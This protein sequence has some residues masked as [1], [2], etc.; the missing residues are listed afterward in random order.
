MG[1]THSND[2][3][4]LVSRCQYVDFT[5]SVDYAILADATIAISVYATQDCWI[6]INPPGTYQAA[7]DPGGEKTP[8]NNQTFVPLGV[9]VDYPVHPTDGAGKIKI[10]VIRDSADG[11][12]HITER[13]V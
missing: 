6:T 8:V 11:R 3:L 4:L 10:S 2:N 9:I 7:A 12:L 5:S 13:K 1:G